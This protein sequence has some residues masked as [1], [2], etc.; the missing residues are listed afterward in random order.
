MAANLSA[1]E[2]R[3]FEVLLR[4]RHQKL[5][6]EIHQALMESDD[7]HWQEMA[8]RVHDSAEESVA[9]L[10]ID[11]NIRQLDS[12]VQELYA[13]ESALARQRNGTY[14]ICVDCGQPIKVERLRAM[15]TAIR[16]ID[17]QSRHER[18]YIQEMP[19]L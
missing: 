2:L 15:P 11:L 4:E 1:K 8:G 3:E 13:V 18:D 17:C 6:Q 12:Q 10:I 9:D 16:C 19:T 5:R 7:V 14:G